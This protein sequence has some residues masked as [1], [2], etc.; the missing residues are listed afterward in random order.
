MRQEALIKSQQLSS[1]QTSL[2]RFVKGA[3]IEE[4][5]AAAAASGASNESNWPFCSN[6]SPCFQALKRNASEQTGSS[7]PT[8]C[9]D[10]RIPYISL[11][12]FPSPPSPSALVSSTQ[13]WR[14]WPPWSFVREKNVTVRVVLGL[15]IQGLSCKF[16]WGVFTRTLRRFCSP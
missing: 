2:A 15:Q 13:L 4:I 10:A 11:L 9:N 6:S 5:P 3:N 8:F 16:P 14:E 12:V 7:N 1:M